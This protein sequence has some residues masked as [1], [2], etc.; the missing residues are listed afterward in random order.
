MRISYPRI[1]LLSEGDI[2]LSQNIL[3]NAS[4]SIPSFQDNPS[5]IN[6]LDFNSIADRSG[7]IILKSNGKIIQDKSTVMADASDTKAGRIL[8]QANG[9]DNAGGIFLY[10]S[11]ILA[12]HGAGNGD[13]LLTSYGGIKLDHSTIDVSSDRYPVHNSKTHELVENDLLPY[14]FRAGAIALNSYNSNPIQ[15]NETNIFARQSTDGGGLE[16]PL[17]RIDTYPNQKYEGRYGWLGEELS[18]TIGYDAGS[19]G[20]ISLFSTGGIKINNSLIDVSSGK[21]PYENL[22]GLISIA[23]QGISGIDLSHSSLSAMAG[24]PRDI[25]N[26]YS[27]SGII[28]LTARN[29]IHITSSSVLANNTSSTET[30]SNPYPIISVYS[31]NKSLALLES[32]L[33]SN[34]LRQP[35]LNSVEYYGINLF[36]ISIVN[37]QT[38]LDPLPL[39]FNAGFSTS[40]ISEFRINEA[41]FF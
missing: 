41:N 29:M 11:Q 39:E 30:L 34:Y 17:F 6:K 15:I 36:P 8:F 38:I 20:F 23:D 31:E 40:S 14:A 18:F 33:Q 28:D 24:T 1:G 2:K 12:R 9:V 26:K 25:S 37:K 22:A 7:L 21:F 4:S 27:N 35:L 19:A 13:I 3:I 16:S 5:Y 32:E 10:N